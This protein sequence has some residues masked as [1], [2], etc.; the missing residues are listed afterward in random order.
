LFILL[1]VWARASNEYD[2]FED[3]MVAELWVP[4]IAPLEKKFLDDA[5]TF[6]SRCVR[7]PVG[8]MTTVMTSDLQWQYGSLQM[9]QPTTIKE[10]SAGDAFSIYGAPLPYWADSIPIDDKDAWTKGIS[11]EIS[12]H[13]FEHGTREFASV[14]LIQSCDPNAWQHDFEVSTGN[15]GT[16]LVT[17]TISATATSSLSEVR[18]T[19]S[20]LNITSGLFDALQVGTEVTVLRASAGSSTP[21]EDVLL[22]PGAEFS[23]P[24]PWINNPLFGIAQPWLSLLVV[25]LWCCTVS[26]SCLLLLECLTHA[27]PHIFHCRTP[28]GPLQPELITVRPHACAINHSSFEGGGERE[29]EGGREGGGGACAVK[30]C[31]SPPHSSIRGGRTFKPEPPSHTKQRKHVAGFVPEISTSHF[32]L[33]MKYFFM[34]AASRS[35][36]DFWFWGHIYLPVPGQFTP[37]RTSAGRL[38]IRNLAPAVLLLQDMAGR[39]NTG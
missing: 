13:G 18:P 34:A 26:S 6:T 33:P 15:D 37:S 28:Q 3:S 21:Q 39:S 11:Y 25:L 7:V 14:L 23:M 5:V 1:G 36:C 17:I 20:E 22:T 30:W 16:P 19:W 35:F 32:L 31:C 27:L 8:K 9:D 2:D 10:G 24:R 38:A 4:L 12:V 29:R